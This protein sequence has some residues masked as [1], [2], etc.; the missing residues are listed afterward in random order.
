MSKIDEFTNACIFFRDSRR[1]AEDIYG[2]CL[3]ASIATRQGDG[4]TFSEM[5]RIIH[6][7][8]YQLRDK[9]NC[10]HV[11]KRQTHV[12]KYGWWEPAQCAICDSILEKGWYCPD[13]PDLIC[14]YFSVT[15]D[16]G[17]ET[18][19]LLDGNEVPCP[20]SRCYD[21]DPCN[22]KPRDVCLNPGVPDQEYQSEDWCLYCGH[23]EERK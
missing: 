5:N 21:C 3:V 22:M 4:I 9:K 17:S 1:E 23:P 15:E 16:D 14:H 10:C 11:V 7:E 8:L 13:S 20:K 2:L 18:V 6:D 12:D 19:M